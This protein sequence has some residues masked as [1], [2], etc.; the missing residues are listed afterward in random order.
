MYYQIANAAN[1]VH[2]LGS[3]LQ[4][5]VAGM[6]GQEETKV[7]IHKSIGEKFK[8]FLGKLGTTIENVGEHVITGAIEGAVQTAAII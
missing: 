3:G 4:T 8:G 5:N 7:P 2:K 6:L 1:T